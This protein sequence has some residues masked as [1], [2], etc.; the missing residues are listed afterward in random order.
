MRVHELTI[1]HN[2][3]LKELQTLSHEASQFRSDIIFRYE[4]D[5]NNQVEL[6]VK[7]LLG[8]MMIPIHKGTRVT[9]VTKGA[10]EKEAID[11]MCDL[12]S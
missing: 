12:L 1:N 11:Y 2:Y 5:E 4:T 9:V 10:D 7:S 6:D 3:H 8:I